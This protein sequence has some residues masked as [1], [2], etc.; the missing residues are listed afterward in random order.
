MQ[1]GMMDD[2]QL[3]F[4]QDNYFIRILGRVGGEG[5]GVGV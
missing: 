2:R 3:S 1:V 5:R 4:S